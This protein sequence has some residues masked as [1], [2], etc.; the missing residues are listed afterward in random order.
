VVDLLADRLRLTDEVSQGI[1]AGRRRG[2]WGGEVVS[3]DS[4]DP[5]SFRR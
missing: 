5:E 4:I 1:Q 3:D 2:R